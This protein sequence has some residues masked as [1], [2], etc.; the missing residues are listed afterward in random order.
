M[1]IVVAMLLG[2]VL[3]GQSVAASAG[4]D[5]KESTPQQVA[6]GAG[7]VLATLVY[8]P[9]KASFCILGG[10]ASAFTAIASPP[11]AGKMVGASCRGT[12]GI[13]PGVLKG[14]DQVRFVGDT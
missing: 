1:R 13:T 3:L 2:A 12:W 5:S 9:F 14:R 6:Y 7:S 8:S 4:V 10:V 11:T